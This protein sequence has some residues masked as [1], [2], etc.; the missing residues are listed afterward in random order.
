MGVSHL[1]VM[2]FLSTPSARRATFASSVG[3]RRHENFYPRPP[4]GGRRADLLAVRKLRRFLST[5]SA[6]RATSAAEGFISSGIISIHALR[7][8][9]DCFSFLFVLTAFSF[10]STPSARRAT[11]SAPVLPATCGISIHALREEGDA[12]HHPGHHRQ[13]ISIHALREE[14]DRAKTFP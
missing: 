8:E 2:Q 5:P 6:R 7:E 14:G 11:A 10:L 13:P 4:R 1:F 12:E 3:H 9:G